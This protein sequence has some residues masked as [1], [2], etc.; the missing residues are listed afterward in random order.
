MNNFYGFCLIFWVCW[1]FWQA[2]YN[3]GISELFDTKNYA[4][5]LDIVDIYIFFSSDSLVQN[6]LI[7]PICTL[8]MYVKSK[9]SLLFK[10][11][12]NH[13]ICRIL[14][15]NVKTWKYVWMQSTFG[16]DLKLDFSCSYKKVSIYT[17][18]CAKEC[19]I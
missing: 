6:F 8:F 13:R 4:W 16:L 14:L 3:F 2:I 11:H 5:V 19:G 7:P 9:T 17:I 15:S 1:F 18:R 12:L 10:N